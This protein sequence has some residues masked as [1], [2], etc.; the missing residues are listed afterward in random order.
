[1]RLDKALHQNP[2]ADPDNLIDHNSI[3]VHKESICYLNENVLTSVV[4][5]GEHVSTKSYVKRNP[6]AKAGF[7]RVANPKDGWKGNTRKFANL[8]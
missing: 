1:M 2:D 7:I 5:K 4:V 6:Y 3:R 8:V